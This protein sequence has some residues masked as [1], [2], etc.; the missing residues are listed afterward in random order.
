MIIWCLDENKK[1]IK[2]YEKLGGKKIITRKAK[3]GDQ[4]YNECGIYFDLVK[5]S[6]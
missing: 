4:I 2:F 3:I 5:L 1:A 6:M